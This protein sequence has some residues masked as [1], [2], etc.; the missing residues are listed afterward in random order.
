M[1]LLL[2]FLLSLQF[3]GSLEYSNHCGPISN[4]ECNGQKNVT[5]CLTASL[6][7]CVCGWCQTTN[8]CV[9]IDSCTMDIVGGCTE[10][11]YDPKAIQNGCGP[12]SDMT[13]SLL[14]ISLFGYIPC[15]AAIIWNCC[16]FGFEGKGKIAFAI[17]CT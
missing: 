13:I 8:T 4:N 7:G 11:E 15:F 5:T 14:I 1:L 17:I 16:C 9:A 2:F 12:E 3:N 6:F 10:I